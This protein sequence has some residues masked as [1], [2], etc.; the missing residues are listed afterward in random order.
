MDDEE[1]YGNQGERESIRQTISPKFTIETKDLLC[2]HCESLK[3]DEVKGEKGWKWD[4]IGIYFIPVTS[5]SEE[6][7]K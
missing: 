1:Y 7:G 5:V 6:N 3:K 2:I 4:E